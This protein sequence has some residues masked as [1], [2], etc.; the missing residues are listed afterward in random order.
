MGSPVRLLSAVTAA[1]S[2][3]MNEA[4][5]AIASAGLNGSRR[6]S[7]F[8][9]MPSPSQV[10]GMNW[11]RPCAPAGLTALGFHPDSCSSWGASRGAVMPGQVWAAC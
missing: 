10:P 11:D 4:W 9:S 2:L 7:P 5:L 8:P 6:P 3:H 1:S